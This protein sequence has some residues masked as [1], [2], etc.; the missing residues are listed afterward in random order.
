MS[1]MKEG[2]GNDWAAILNGHVDGCRDGNYHVAAWAGWNAKPTSGFSTWPQGSQTG[3]PP[4]SLAVCQAFLFTSP[5]S[6]SFW[7][8]LDSRHHLQACRAPAADF[9]P[10]HNCQRH[11]RMPGQIFPVPTLFPGK[12]P[13][14]RTRIVHPASVS[15]TVMVSSQNL[16]SPHT[17]T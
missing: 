3:R 13:I 16:S 8:R 1:Q 10:L 5:S 17:Y 4:P 14:L 12:V 6:C 7:K 9:C 11:R 2:G 15:P